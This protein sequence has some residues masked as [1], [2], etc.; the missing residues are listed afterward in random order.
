MV[1]LDE[2]SPSR[3]SKV[4]MAHETS[5]LKT[6]VLDMVEEA[7]RRSVDGA[8][9]KVLNES[10]ERL[11]TLREY[12]LRGVLVVARLYESTAAVIREKKREG[13]S[14]RAEDLAEDVAQH[15]GWL[16]AQN[17]HNLLR[18]AYCTE[19][20][21]LLEKLVSTPVFRTM[22]QAKYESSAKFVYVFEVAMWLLLGVSYSVTT[23]SSQGLEIMSRQWA[24]ATVFFA[25]PCLYYFVVRTDLYARHFSQFEQK[26]DRQ[27]RQTSRRKKL[28]K[29]LRVS[30]PQQESE[31]SIFVEGVGLSRESKVL[32]MTVET[33][34]RA[35]RSISWAWRRLMWVVHRVVAAMALLA[36]GVPFCLVLTFYCP[37]AIR[38]KA[39]AVWRWFKELPSYTPPPPLLVKTNEKIDILT[40]LGLPR[41]WRHD[42]INWVEAFSLFAVLSSY[43][44]CGRHVT[45]QSLVDLLAIGTLTFWLRLLGF[46]RGVRQFAPFVILVTNMLLVD[47]RAF[48]VVFAVIFAGFVHAVYYSSIG[49]SSNP[50]DSAQI[51]DDDPMDPLSGRMMDPI[52]PALIGAN[53]F[54]EVTSLIYTLAFTGE[55]P[56][57]D[58]S[59]LSKLDIIFHCLVVMC[60]SVVMLNVLIA[61]VAD[62]YCSAISRSDDLFWRSRFELVVSTTAIWGDLAEFAPT[63]EARIRDILDHELNK[64][65]EEMGHS[66]TRLAT[67]YE[68]LC[69]LERDKD[70]R[71]LASIIRQ[72][73]NGDP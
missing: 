71:D 29:R 43:L 26:V 72:H 5:S 57:V 24:M 8:L 7:G 20:A 51:M 69:A 14:E 63:T 36:Y 18:L 27:K 37:G 28:E 41:A 67:I 53:R 54:W 22:V 60:M 46:L 50:H 40:S 32:E 17:T 58:V 61:I 48:I 52:E 59:L 19:D 42:F 12:E 68:K 66:S 44:V 35:F 64:D 15:V 10:F 45:R 30:S 73:T 1:S 33:V 21:R 34:N 55:I 62:A 56:S 65:P 3:R 38:A 31:D 47:M 11:V 23:L 6:L 13:D 4:M 39:P 25:H 2:M 49:W 70:R 9:E 16:C